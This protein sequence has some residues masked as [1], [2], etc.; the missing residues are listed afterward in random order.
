M[1]LQ[2]HRRE[3]LVWLRVLQ[4]GSLDARFGVHGQIRERSPRA[5]H[6]INC[7]LSD[8]R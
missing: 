2:F 7:T 4:C 3:W 8:D 1:V 6:P 5:N